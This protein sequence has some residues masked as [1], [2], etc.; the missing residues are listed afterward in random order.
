[1]EIKNSLRFAAQSA[2]ELAVYLLATGL[3][4]KME[5]PVSLE[6]C[7][8]DPHWPA[9]AELMKK[10]NV[11]CTSET[12]F[13]KEE[14]SKAQWLQVRSTWHY[15]YPQPEGDFFSKN[16]TYSFDGYCAAC[17]SGLTQTAPFRVKKAPKWGKRSFCQLNWIDDELFLSESAKNV[18]TDNGIDCISFMPVLNKAGKEELPDFYQLIIPTILESALIAEPPVIDD[19]TA[20]PH[21]GVTKYHTRGNGMLRFKKE[22]FANAPD[23]VKTA[24]VFGW[25]SGAS[26]QIIISQKVYQMITKN[27]MDRDLV[28]EVVELV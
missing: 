19:I 14:L 16:F 8:S 4:K 9:I 20:C 7:E 28:F 23:I 10:G 26:R 21:C 11:I 22:A 15:E 13:S 12:I 17:G 18:F 1:M 24:E 25:G 6:I 5:N 27:R 2:P 3:I